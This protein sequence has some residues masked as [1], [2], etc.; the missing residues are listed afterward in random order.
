[1]VSAHRVSGHSVIPINKSVMTFLQRS[2]TNDG[3]GTVGILQFYTMVLSCFQPIKELLM[4]I[5]NKVFISSSVLMYN[6]VF[7]HSRRNIRHQTQPKSAES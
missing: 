5:T 1:M 3:K 6:G 4:E 2:Y 7:M